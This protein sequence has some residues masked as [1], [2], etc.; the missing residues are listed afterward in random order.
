[1]LKKTLYSGIGLL[2]IALAFLVFNLISG[3]L[4][5]HARLDLTEQKLYTLSE[6]TIRILNSLQQPVELQFFFSDELARDVPALRN[7]ARRVEEMLKTYVDRSAGKI[8]LKRIDPKPFSEEEDQAAELGLQGVPMQQMGDN[9]YFGL[10]GR[11]ALG[12]SESREAIPFFQQDREAFLEYE[13]SRLI[14]GLAQTERPLVGILSGLAMEGGF[15]FRTQQPTGPWVILEEVRQMFRL[16]ALPPATTQIPDDVSVLMLVHPKE[17]PEPTLYAID[18][19]VLRG[20][21]LLAFVDPYSEVDASMDLSALQEDIKPIH[22]S[23]VEAL[24]KA[25]GLRL[26]PDR[27]VAD[28]SYAISVNVDGQ[29]RPVR[30][31][32]W[33]S[34]SSSALDKQDVVSSELDVL[35]MATVGALEPLPNAT[36]RFTPLVHS[37]QEALLVD[38]QRLANLNN[39]RELVKGLKASGTNYTLAARVQGPVQS[40][41]PSGIEGRPEG[42]K[43]A[44]SINVIVVADTDFLADRMWVQVQEFFG[45]SIP[46]P[47]ADNASLVIN[48]LDNLAGSDALISVRSRGRYSR[49]FTR[50]EAIQRDAEEQFREKEERLQQRLMATEQRLV[51]LQGANAQAL[52]MSPEQQRTLQQFLQEKLAIRK[53]LREVRYDLN[54]DI[55]ALGRSLK[56]IN[57]ALM[58]LLLTLGALFWLWRQRRIKP[59]FVD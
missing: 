38:T 22:N 2:L 17:L 12:D 7:Y 51:E 37:S 41:F 31:P 42:L 16:Q 43:S 27:V 11:S 19:F 28:Q 59:T 18:Q 44:D 6:G 5:S 23:N 30:H 48:A 24:F 53:E 32:A 57:I 25:W 3:V 35:T 15:D 50:V 58:P 40:A 34:L 4:F 52:E 39:P 47:W 21:K 29:S 14:Q 49:P 33:L 10:V 8:T 36:T 55:E 20:G 45:Q 54:A 56:F 46:T 1:M 13:I 9:L 26:V